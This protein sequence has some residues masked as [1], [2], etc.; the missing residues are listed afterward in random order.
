MYKK[1]AITKLFIVFAFLLAVVVLVLLTDQ[2]KGKRTFRSDLFDAD[3]ADIT[4]IIIQSGKVH[5]EALTFVKEASE[6]MLKSDD[7]KFHADDNMIH[8][9]LRTLNDL[10]AERVAATDK[11]RWKE[12]EVEDSLATKVLVKKG[13]KTI[14]C[15]YV[16]KFSYQM[17]KNANP[18]D[19]YQQPKISTFVRVDNDKIVYVAEGFLSMIF[20]RSINDYRNQV[21][22]R[23][24][25]NDWNRLTFTYPGDSSFTLTKNKG[26]WIIDGFVVDSSKTAEY[27]ASIA[28]VASPDFV[29]DLKP[30]SG[31]PDLSLKIEGN[32]RIS[33]IV[34]SAFAADTTHG[35][36]VSSSENEGV[37][38]SG[39]KS[40]LFNRL[41][42]SK[43]R[44]MLSR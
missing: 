39:K 42:I 11:S 18:Y 28:S 5:G 8:E 44:L 21:M 26:K 2:K 41:F 20:N 37:F 27:L 6:W 17:P 3:T 9:I 13:K 32:N 35:Y 22:I 33:P 16:G 14:S 25:T 36:L 43:K 10:K 29:D 4:S 19:Y 40:E 23:G 24:N 34:V 12:F 7:K 30:A 31:K 1:S 38:F 15:I